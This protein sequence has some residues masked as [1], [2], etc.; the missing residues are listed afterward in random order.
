MVKVSVITVAFQS[1][2]V[3]GRTLESILA[4]DYPSI[5]YWIIEG[6]GIDKT[7]KIANQYAQCFQEKGID[8]H[9]ISEPDQ[10][11]Y[12]AMNK[13]IKLATGGIIGIL[14]S[15]DVYEPDAIGTAVKN[16]TETD[17]DLMFGNI[18]I[19][20]TN[21]KSFLKKA[22]QRKYYQT[23]RDWNHPTMFV[24]SE[25]YKQH[26]FQNKGIHDDYAFYLKM[27]K[28]K[29][30]VT[31]VDKVMADFYMGG[32]SNQKKLRTAWKR[33][34]DRYQYCYRENGY[35]RWYFLEC[36]FMETVKWILG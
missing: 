21:G 31:V 18:M 27:R 10:G 26:P 13:G 22:R 20:K 6:A 8:Y 9:V 12:D 15:G 17:C 25:L 35:S 36:V 32:A 28:D 23:S 19:H 29:C 11:L 1:E 14:N 33:I 24:R 7:T 16:L 2:A 4:Q 5:E 34:Q 3:I 30:K